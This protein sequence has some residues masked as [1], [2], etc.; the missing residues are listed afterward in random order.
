[1][2]CRQTMETDAQGLFALTNGMQRGGIECRMKQCK[3]KENTMND[4][5]SRLAA[6]EEI[7]VRLSFVLNP[8]RSYHI[9]HDGTQENQR[10][11][12]MQPVTFDA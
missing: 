4:M 9:G 3:Q 2:L 8:Q 11:A 6:A 12:L 7:I 10:E 1:M 5:E